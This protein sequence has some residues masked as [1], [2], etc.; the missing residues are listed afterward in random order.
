MIQQ[1]YFEA[2]LLFDVIEQVASSFPVRKPLQVLRKPQSFELGGTIV[3][4]GVDQVF[5]LVIGLLT[6]ITFHA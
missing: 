2:S 1:Q 4:E 5:L 3:E 6:L